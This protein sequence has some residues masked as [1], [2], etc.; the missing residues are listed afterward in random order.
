MKRL[1]NDEQ[2]A[3]LRDIS[4]ARTSAQ[5]AEM[6]NE[7]FNL[8]LSAAQIKNYRSKHKIT[9][10]V[11]PGTLGSHTGE[12]LFSDEIVEFIKNNYKA[13]F[14]EELTDLVN[15]KFGTNYKDKQI[16]AYKKRNKL[17]SGM[18]CH[19]EEGHVPFTK[20]KKQ[21]EYMSEEAIERSKET[22]FKKGSKPWNTASI[23]EERI[24][25]EGYLMV[26]INDI[27]N[28]GMKKNW[29]LKARLVWEKH[30]GQKIPPGMYIAYLDGNKL[31]CD[32]S[33]L[34]LV[35]NNE[36]LYLNRYRLRT[37]NQELTKAAVAL[38]KFGCKINEI[39]KDRKDEK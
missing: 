9:T 33:N 25:T 34:A 23:G 36:N 38:A 24:T 39:E 1:L 35:N 4:H 15:K 29:I 26:K 11:P 22:R 17:D 7:K 30:H 37:D 6:L 10:G 21:T 13:R 3:Y 32:P 19:F 5:C 31:N 8:K 27:P 2:D 18:R 28:G 14:N 20:G 12:R 16:S